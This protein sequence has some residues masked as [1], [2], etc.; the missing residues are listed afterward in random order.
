MSPSTLY[1]FY[2]YGS[3]LT[4]QTHTLLIFPQNIAHDLTN[5]FDFSFTNVSQQLRDFLGYRP[6]DRQ[7][8]PVQLPVYVVLVRGARQLPTAGVRPAEHHQAA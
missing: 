2:F 3:L 6:V 4:T 8:L 7:L 1:H 5:I